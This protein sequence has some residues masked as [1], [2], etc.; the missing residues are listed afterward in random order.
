MDKKPPEERARSDR[1]ETILKQ[2]W[3]AFRFGVEEA[4]S[5]WRLPVVGTTGSEGAELRT[6]VLREANEDSRTLVF[7]TDAR[8]RKVKELEES[9]HAAWLFFDPQSGVQ[10]RARSHVAMHQ[11]DELTW[12]LWKR[13]PQDARGN[14][15]NSQSPGEPTVAR[16]ETSLCDEEA[17]LNFVVVECEVVFLDWL[18]ISQDGH[19][20][21]QFNWG[22]HAW[23][24][25]SVAP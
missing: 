7:H 20:R 5:P 1:L 23:K 9:G 22:G 25:V 19:Q 12:K 13:V 8:S 16:P 15:S 3:S 11:D 6:V 17:F 2:C 4:N 18:Q 21:V 14:Y 24:G 10:I